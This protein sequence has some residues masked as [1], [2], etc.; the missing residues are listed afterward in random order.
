MSFFP[1]E[2]FSLL[3]SHLSHEELWEAR[4]TCKE[5]KKFVDYHFKLF[6]KTIG[7]PRTCG[8][9]HY[10][11]INTDNFWKTSEPTRNDFS[12]VNDSIFNEEFIMIYFQSIG[13]NLVVGD[14]IEIGNYSKILFT[15]EEE[16]LTTTRFNEKN[17]T[18]NFG[19]S[20]IY[21][22]NGQI[23]KK[24]KKLASLHPFFIHTE[25]SPPFPQNYWKHYCP[26]SLEHYS[27]DTSRSMSLYELKKLDMKKTIANIPKDGI[28][29][30]GIEKT[31]THY[32]GYDNIFII[33]SDKKIIEICSK[34]IKYL[35]SG[36]QRYF[37][38]FFEWSGYKYTIVLD[39]YFN[40]TDKIK[41]IKTILKTSNELF[42]YYNPAF[43]SKDMFDHDILFLKCDIFTF[44]KMNTKTVSPQDIAQMFN[45][46]AP[47]IRID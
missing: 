37:T 6:V 23:S 30:L 39:K 45:M 14:I 27:N 11:A 28:R 41:D 12:Y 10:Y 38:S 22:G 5:W 40:T 16:F 25:K 13:K 19:T 32:S 9:C 47:K 34:N 17:F 44:T 43:I 20:G 3:F 24:F 26:V 15:N 29:F 35:D 8:H 33:F 1:S 7:F 36:N 2:I 21:T 46:I 4:L 42:I 31:L 18:G